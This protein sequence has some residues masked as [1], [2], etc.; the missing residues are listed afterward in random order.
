MLLKTVWIRHFYVVKV[1]SLV[2]L[3]YRFG[4][5]RNLHISKLLFSHFARTLNSNLVPWRPCVVLCWSSFVWRHATEI[6]LCNSFNWLALATLRIRNVEY[7][8]QPICGN[9]ERLTTLKSITL[10]THKR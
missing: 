9:G 6:V 10:S 2:T 5:Q 4:H 1:A 8:L 3:I 7:I